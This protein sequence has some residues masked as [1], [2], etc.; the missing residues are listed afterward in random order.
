MEGNTLEMLPEIPV[1]IQTII[2]PLNSINPAKGAELGPSHFFK[3]Q[4]N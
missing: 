3:T 2:L 4:T 1:A